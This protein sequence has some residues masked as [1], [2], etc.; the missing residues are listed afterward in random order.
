MQAFFTRYII[1][2][3]AVS[4]E[5]YFHVLAN[6]LNIARL[7]TAAFANSSIAETTVHPHTNTLLLSHYFYYNTI[8]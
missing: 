5:I 7:C 2:V 4:S 1:I 6:K 3:L 8:C